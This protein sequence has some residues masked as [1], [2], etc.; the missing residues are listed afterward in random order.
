MTAFQW[1]GGVR[2]GSQEGLTGSESG[3][4][5]QARGPGRP[6]HSCIPRG[7][8]QDGEWRGRRAEQHSPA[9]ERWL[10]GRLLIVFFIQILFT[11]SFPS[12]CCLRGFPKLTVSKLSRGTVWEGRWRNFPPSDHSD[13]WRDLLLISIRGFLLGT[14]LLPDSQQAPLSGNKRVVKGSD[15]F[16]HRVFTIQWCR[17]LPAPRY[18]PL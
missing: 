14:P 16:K 8:P 7:N 10:L 17:P 1:S 4:A 9:L 12:L 11:S 2:G 3:L 6:R 5:A 13:A 18:R 15:N